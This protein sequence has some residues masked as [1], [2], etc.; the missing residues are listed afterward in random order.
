MTSRNWLG[1]FVLACATISLTSAAQQPPP[2]AA[3]PAIALVDPA[4]AAQWQALAQGPGWRILAG[5]LPPGTADSPDARVQALAAAVARAVREGVDPARIYLA[6]RGAATAAVFYTISRVPDLWAA[7]IG[8][9][10]SPQA[11]IVTDRLFA[12][13]FTN[14]PVLWIGRDN[15]DPGLAARL[16]D[17]GVNLEYRPAAG[18]NN[19]AVLDWLAGHHREAFPSAIDC[20]TN[21]PA[22]ASCYWIQMSKFDPQ[23]R[24]DMLPTTRIAAA[25]AASLNVGNFGYKP[26]EPGPGL[27]VT[28]LPERYNGP[29]KVGDRIV[30]L[31]GRPL[32]NA[33]AYL[34]A[35]AKYTEEKPVVA[36]VQRGKDRIRL[37]TRIVVP[38]KDP[39][40]TARV[41]AKYL[42]AERELQIV[43]RTVKEMRV[44]IPP[45][46][47]DESRLYWNG[48]A[49]EKIEG[50]GCYV[51]TEESELLHATRCP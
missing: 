28:V 7:A 50:A 49:L 24:N 32:E 6:G 21:A 31:E 14:V 43:T 19:Q 40:V 48:L 11:A 41:Q 27:L 4:D 15:S 42:P 45:Q 13:N 38:R 17:A 35:M 51:L 22:F 25:A 5:T 46:W 44:T 47:V 39:V 37:E 12:A 3:V 8:I 36:T 29:L 2:A 34:D 33:R 9:D 10:G 16:K 23:E 18:I 20:E 30:A 26:D 1:K